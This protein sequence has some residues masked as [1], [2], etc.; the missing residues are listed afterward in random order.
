MRRHDLQFVK[1][2]LEELDPAMRPLYPRYK[3]QRL[4]QVLHE[5]R[6]MC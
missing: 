1:E 3:F 2:A 4:I 5:Y 6:A